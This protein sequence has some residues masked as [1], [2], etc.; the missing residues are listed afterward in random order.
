MPRIVEQPVTRKIVVC[1]VGEDVT[2]ISAQEKG[3]MMFT[4]DKKQAKEFGLYSL[5]F[6]LDILKRRKI[7]HR[8]IP[9]TKI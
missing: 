2:Y 9:L 7:L 1:S 6:V 3:E 8:D 5:V 4:P